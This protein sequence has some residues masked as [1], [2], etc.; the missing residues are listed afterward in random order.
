MQELINLLPVEG[1]KIVM[2]IFLSFLIGLE[3]EECRQ[4]GT[5]YYFGGVRTFPLVGLVGYAMALIS[6]QNLL[7]VA[8]G[9]A[10]VGAF[11]LV[12][13]KHKL[14][15]AEAAGATTEFTGLETYVLGALVYY[16]HYWVAS[17][18]V[19]ASMLLLELKGAL[20][21]LASK[22]PLH[23]IVTFT[24]F[25]V[26]TAVIL[27]VLPN[28]DFTAFHLN[29]FQ[30]WVV[31]VAVCAISYASY[32]LEWLTKERGEI[33]ISALL[34][35]AYSSTMTAIVLAKKSKQH[36]RPHLLSGAMLISSSASYFRIFI[37]VAM[38]SSALRSALQWPLLILALAAFVAGY[39]FTKIPDPVTSKVTRDH[40][41]RNPLEL[42]AAL[43]FGASVV[44]MT[45]ITQL[46]VSYLGETGVYALAGLIGVTSPVPFI[47][48]LTQSVGTAIPLPHAASA[49]VI[50]M[51]SNNIVK[52]LY[53]YGIARNKTGLYSLILQ[54]ALTVAGLLPILLI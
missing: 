4:H 1:L 53:A 33:I 32:V 25:L 48:S 31:V 40:Q 6:G 18:I 41:H 39:L 7:P 3:R 42:K 52:G 24:K 15:S 14:A 9:F 47:M 54:A 20:E 10:V 13:Y 37:L 22:L 30:T 2:V 51:A 43:F 45:I 49:I 8:L 46:V 44:A 50:T 36:D 26:L 34:G 23:E 17:T 19:V 38:F 27:P 16:Q 28:R 35:G 11:L 29:P 5:H 21:E 12:S